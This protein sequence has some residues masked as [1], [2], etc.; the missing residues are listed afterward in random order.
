MTRVAHL[1][2]LFS[3]ALVACGGRVNLDADEMNETGTPPGDADVLL[4]G[5]RDTEL[6]DTRPITGFRSYTVTVGAVKATWMG[7]PPTPGITHPSQGLQFRADLDAGIGFDGGS[8][9]VIAAKWSDA[10][11]ARGCCGS[12]ITFRNDEKT[13][14]AQVRGSIGYGQVDDWINALEVT[15]D[16]VGR[17]VSGRIIGQTQ[18]IQGDV[19]WSGDIE[20]T[21]TF[22]P[23]TTRPE[24][25]G[26]SA[27]T[28]ASVPLPWDVRTVETSEP[29]VSG[30]DVASLFG[31]AAKGLQPMPIEQKSW[32][33]RAERGMRVRL[34]DWEL[35][36]PLTAKAQRVRDEAGNFANVS[37]PIVL[38]GARVAKRAERYLRF[39]DYAGA[40]F[41]WGAAKVGT[42]GCRPGKRCVAIGPFKASYCAP[43]SQGGVATRLPGGGP[44]TVQLRG[45][46]R[47]ISTW[48][49][50]TKPSVNVVHLAGAAPGIDAKVVSSTLTW[51]ATPGSDGTL[52]SGWTTLSVSTPISE[53]VTES[54]FAVSGGGIG[55]AA[56]GCGYYGGP[57]MPEEWEITLY[58]EEIALP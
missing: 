22:A 23:D 6:P 29:Y 20:A 24:W 34:V 17:P 8:R 38:E 26:S 1:G 46:A 37:A 10:V 31:D 39:D 19:A 35:P 43:G 33:G 56:S 48:G 47:R 2:F 32:I 55:R 51:P 27:A 41:L 13:A 7:A 25:R 4:D 49:G 53:K 21:V 40:A 52:D 3:L 50:S 45:V 16:A 14:L 36:T 54:A 15:F 18:L 44:A 58:V 28:F 5:D 11:L 30:V 57:P 9:A 12:K 42:T